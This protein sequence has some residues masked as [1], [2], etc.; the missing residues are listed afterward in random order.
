MFQG[1]INDLNIKKQAKDLGVSIWQAP[2]FL[3]LIMGL[4]IMMAMALVYFISRH[5]DSPEILIISETIVVT[6]ILIL[7][8]SI[9]RNLEMLAKTNKMKSEFVSIASH[10]LK[11]PLSEI[12]WG[13]ELLLSKYKD[14]LS[15]K[16]LEIIEGV[17]KS[18]SRLIKLANN[19]LDVA[20]ISQEKFDLKKEKF[21]IW[22]IARRAVE[23]NKILAKADN[24]EINLEKPRESI[25]NVQ[26]DSRRIKAVVDGLL[27]NAIKYSKEKDQVRIKIKNEGAYTN[28]CIKDS[29]L[30][31]PINEQ[32]G[33][34]K[35]F[36][37]GRNVVKL[38]TEGTG[39]GLYLAKNIIEECGGKIW[40]KSEEGKG[41][42]FYFSLLSCK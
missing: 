26:G 18:N 35:K 10:E 17:I 1:I 2:S 6:T 16:Q 30:G 31:I 5:Y 15:E 23:E 11:T 36:F 40:F 28:V 8:S 41:S 32:K 9:I 12:R 37:R 20:V 25:F 27:S 19:L 22:E 42:A 13:T 4:V 7:G 14:G 34:F 21:D 33:V 29:G 39:L 38:K 3:F 24:I